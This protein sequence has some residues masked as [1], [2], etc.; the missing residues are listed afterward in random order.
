MLNNPIN[1]NDPTGHEIGSL[2]D[3]GYCDEND[4][5]IMADSPYNIFFKL[6]KSK[7]VD[8]W[9]TET[10]ASPQAVELIKN[11]EVSF[12]VPLTTPYNDANNYCTVGYGH[13]LAYHMCSENELR[14]TYTNEQVDEWFLVDLHEAER[15]VRASF[16]HLDNFYRPESQGYP[17]GNPAPI[18]QAQF[19]ALVSFAY[20]RGTVVED[21][22]FKSVIVNP[23]STNGK[24]DPEVFTSW[25]QFYADQNNGVQ[26]R[27]TQEINWFLSGNYPTSL[28]P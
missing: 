23:G 20:N 12:L 4:D 11:A 24:F 2:C 19:D 18:T 28:I 25:M 3:R 16:Q 14:V 5:P 1:F 15:L 17:P 10:S 6:P 26:Y 8:V 13:V 22:I 7:D 21:V 9:D 27:R